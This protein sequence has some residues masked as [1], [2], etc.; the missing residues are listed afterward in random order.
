[1]GRQLRYRVICTT[2]F[3][4]SHTLEILSLK[5]DGATRAPIK[6]EADNGL[7]NVRGSLSM[8]RTSDPHS[9]T[10]QFFLNV[11]DNAFLDFTAPNPNG[12]GYAVFAEVV[13]G[14][15]VADQIVAVPTGSVGHHGDVPLEEVLI[16]TATV[17]D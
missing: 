17:D 9:A 8:A 13:E 7:K 12:W 3:E 14:M 11:V 2:N 1:L 6:N 16:L 15:D 4:R 10:S 5:V